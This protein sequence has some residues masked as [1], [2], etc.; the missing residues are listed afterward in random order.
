MRRWRIYDDRELLA[1]A[2]AEEIVQAVQSSS[3]LFTLALSG[4]TTPE[5]VYQLLAGEYA[6]RIEWPRVR[7]ILGDERYVPIDHPSSNTRMVEELLIHPLGLTSEQWITMDTELDWEDCVTDYN[8]RIQSVNLDLVLLGMG[9]DSHTASLFP[10]QFD[11]DAQAKAVK[12]L[13]PV[14]PHQRISLSLPFI[15]SAKC[16]LFLV[17][18][19]EKA[20]TV[21]EVLS[22]PPSEDFPSSMVLPDGDCLWLLDKAAASEL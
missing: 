1:R 17:G 22:N 18:G 12:G 7:L 6:N 13:A 16:A 9:N 4:G 15:N 8:R 11:P 5:A 10:R 21:S 20:C 2:A 19:E 3:G 14:A